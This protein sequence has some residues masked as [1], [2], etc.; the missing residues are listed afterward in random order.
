[1]LARCGHCGGMGVV[2]M[3]VL[4]QGVVVQERRCVMCS[5]PYMAERGWHEQGNQ[6]GEAGASVASTGDNGSQYPHGVS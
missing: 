5:R 1:M 6:R 4:E 3:D 2:V